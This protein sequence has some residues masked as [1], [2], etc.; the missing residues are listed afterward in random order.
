MR[1][2]DAPR[3]S[4]QRDAPADVSATPLTGH[5]VGDVVAGFP[6]V[7]LNTPVT[8]RS[9]SGRSAPAHRHLAVPESAHSSSLPA[10]GS[11]GP[12]LVERNRS[13][14]DAA[15]FPSVFPNWFPRRWGGCWHRTEMGHV[16]VPSCERPHKAL[17]SRV[18]SVLAK[19]ECPGT[20]KASPSTEGGSPLLS[21]GRFDVDPESGYFVSFMAGGF[22]RGDLPGELATLVRRITAIGRCSGGCFDAKQQQSDQSEHDR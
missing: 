14:D 21:I 5:P 12:H 7:A 17:S 16:P 11:E 18:C 22:P 9:T 10:V 4:I 19:S 13:R 6:E 2:S 20:L 8:E 1:G 3:M 15:T